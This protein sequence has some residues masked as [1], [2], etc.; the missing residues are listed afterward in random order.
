MT[1]STKE[2]AVLANTV[3]T[4]REI[5]SRNIKIT[6]FVAAHATLQLVGFMHT[7]NKI[8]G[9][10]S[11]VAL[12]LTGV[13]V[14]LLVISNRKYKSAITMGGIKAQIAEG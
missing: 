12:T 5:V 11:V 2:K 4:L 6:A 3:S 8:V 14:V 7:G 10:G 1:E 9:A 13:M